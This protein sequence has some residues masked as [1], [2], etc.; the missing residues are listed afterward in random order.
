MTN[1]KKPSDFQFIFENN[2]TVLSIYKPVCNRN[3]NQVKLVIFT[4]LYSPGAT[5]G[6]TDKPF[7][8]YN[9]H[10]IHVPRKIVISYSHPCSGVGA[11]GKTLSVLEMYNRNPSRI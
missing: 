4:Q 7:H 8:T 5:P 1:L 3:I 6:N 10:N 2:N 11:S 9:V